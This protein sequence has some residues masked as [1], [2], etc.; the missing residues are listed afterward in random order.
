MT[1]CLFRKYT[2]QKPNDGSIADEMVVVQSWL[3]IQTRSQGH[4]SACSKGMAVTVAF[5]APSI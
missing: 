2:I 3:D 5:T 4:D 1:N